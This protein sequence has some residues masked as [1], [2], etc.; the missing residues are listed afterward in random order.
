VSREPVTPAL[1]TPK[2]AAAYLA[3]S[4]R[5]LYTLPLRRVK[6][7]TAARYERS[8]LDLFISLNATRPSI[9][10]AS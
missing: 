8:E 9:R 5:K 7:G 4:L 6:I 10:K 2:E 3:I 1:L